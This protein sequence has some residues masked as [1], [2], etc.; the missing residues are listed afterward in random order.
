MARCC[1]DRKWSM[2]RLLIPTPSSPPLV[3]TRIIIIC[4]ANPLARWLHNTFP[5]LNLDIPFQFWLKSRIIAKTLLN[6]SL[7]DR[8]LP[9][10]VATHT[11]I[12]IMIVHLIFKAKVLTFQF[13]SDT[14][15]S[16]MRTLFTV[17]TYFVLYTMFPFVLFCRSPTTHR[18]SLYLVRG[19]PKQITPVWRL[20]LSASRRLKALKSSAPHLSRSCMYVQ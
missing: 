16:S 4:C 9:S 2:S 19:A 10:T 14:R 15:V 17:T 18:R 7:A 13:L 20:I 3:S 1:R 11:F 8:L 6:P 12:P 5:L